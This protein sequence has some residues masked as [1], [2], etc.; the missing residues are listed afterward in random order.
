LKQTPIAGHWAP[1]A[2]LSQNRPRVRHVMTF[3]QAN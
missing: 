3:V 1:D 2:G